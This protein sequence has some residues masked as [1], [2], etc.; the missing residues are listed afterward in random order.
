[1]TGFELPML[2]E[3]DN[4]GV[5]HLANSWSVGGRTRH[6]DV[7]MFLLRELKEDG[8]LAFK[9]VSV[10][11]TSPTF[12]PKMWMPQLCINTQSNFVEKMT[13]TVCSRSL[14]AKEGCGSFV[15]LQDLF[16]WENCGTLIFTNMVYTSEQT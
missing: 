5:C 16:K 4:S 10:R 6:V 14:E 1:M 2:V 3:M 12:L 15:R 11:R 8:L 9:H 7:R 13:C